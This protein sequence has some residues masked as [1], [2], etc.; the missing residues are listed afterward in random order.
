LIWTRRE[1]R[2]A[3][4]LVTALLVFGFLGT[5]VG[6]HYRNHYFILV[7]RAVALLAAGAVIVARRWLRDVNLPRAARLIPA[8][9]IL[10]ATTA[11]VLRQADFLF[12]APPAE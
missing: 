5:S 12:L 1:L 10:F 2:R 9:A 8:G 7:F 6:F 11:F 3:A 4:T